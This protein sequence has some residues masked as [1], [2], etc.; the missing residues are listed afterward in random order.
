M[1]I[2]SAVRTHMNLVALL[3]VGQFVKIS[4][5]LLKYPIFE[6]FFFIFSL[7]KKPTEYEF[8][9]VEAS[10]LKSWLLLM[11]ENCKF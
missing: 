2:P 1:Y 5:I 3:L 7:T 8:L 9:Y 6:V 11:E 4:A 10:P